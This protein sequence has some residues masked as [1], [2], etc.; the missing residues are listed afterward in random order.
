VA[1][2]EAPYTADEQFGN[3]NITVRGFE[4]NGNYA[5]NSE[6]ALGIGFFNIMYFINSKNIKVYNMYMHDGIG[7]EDKPG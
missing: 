1:C 5:G 7:D 6:I 3:E 4:V 2:D